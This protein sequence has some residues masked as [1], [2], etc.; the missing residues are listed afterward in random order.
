MKFVLG[1]DGSPK[2]IGVINGKKCVVEYAY[3][4]MRKGLIPDVEYVRLTGRSLDDDSILSEV[5]H[6]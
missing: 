5:I 3:A 1:D 6:K 2:L 4:Q